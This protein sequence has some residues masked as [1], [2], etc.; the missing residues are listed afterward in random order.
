M[1]YTSLIRTGE[2]VAPSFNESAHRYTD[3]KT[4][5]VLPSVSEVIRPLTSMAYARVDEETLKKAS[6]FGT[7]V[8]KICELLDAEADTLD[9]L[10]GVEAE[11]VPPVEAYLKWRD[12]TAVK[13]LG[14]ELRLGCSRFAGTLDRL[15]E[16]DGEPWVIDLKTCSQIHRHVGVQ[17][18]GYVALAQ[19][20]T[21]ELKGKIIRRG[22][23]QITK[24]GNF[25]LYEFR[26]LRDF[27][28]FNALLLVHE[29]NKA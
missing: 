3:G 24:D 4:G 26:D 10:E 13:Y 19:A 23:L 25:K 17:L 5:E 15:A 6:F 2:A 18:A 21:P 20:S 12:V 1:D 16:I 27:A 22:A 29:W 8:H 28:V 9:D 11:Q 7:A 14:V